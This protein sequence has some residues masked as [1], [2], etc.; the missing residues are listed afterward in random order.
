MLFGGY[1]F[2]MLVVPV[3]VAGLCVLGLYMGLL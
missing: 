2:V 3:V 1:G